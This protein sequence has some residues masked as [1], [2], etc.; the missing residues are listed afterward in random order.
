[1][2]KN[3]WA[4]GELIHVVP[5][6]LATPVIVTQLLSFIVAKNIFKWK[7]KQKQNKKKKHN[8]INP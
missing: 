2:W 4:V 8:T 1:M 6:K 5:A 7:Q 3:F